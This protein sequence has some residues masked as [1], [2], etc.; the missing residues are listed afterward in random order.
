MYE[1]SFNYVIRKKFESYGQQNVAIK[2]FGYSYNISREF[3]RKLN[4]HIR[5]ATSHASDLKIIR[6]YGLSIFACNELRQ[7]GK[8]YLEGLGSE[9]GVYGVLPFDAPEILRE[10]VYT[11]SGIY[12][13][14]M[15]MW[16]LTSDQSKAFMIL[17]A[18]GYARVKTLCC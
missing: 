14:G 1:W 7:E 8:A 11:A 10:G 3:L 17:L 5:C 4:A 9:F 15:I 2:N 13:F 6:C 16:E 12:S 18:L